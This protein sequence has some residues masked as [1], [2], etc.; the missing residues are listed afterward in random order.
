MTD[1][2]IA[3]TAYF[4]KIKFLAD[5]RESAN[6]F[7]FRCCLSDNNKYVDEYGPI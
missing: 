6:V 3:F 1:A 4:S 7:A 5:R 2:R